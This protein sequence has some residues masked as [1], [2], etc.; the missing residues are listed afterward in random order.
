MKLTAA[1][2]TEVGDERSRTVHNSIYAILNGRRMRAR[3]YEMASKTILR[4]RKKFETRLVNEINGMQ[5]MQRGN[6]KSRYLK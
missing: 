2:T 5:D 4:I 6:N 3:E 1:R